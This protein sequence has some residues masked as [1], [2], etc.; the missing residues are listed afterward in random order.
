MK[1]TAECP[2]CCVIV[3]HDSD[4]EWVTCPECG[5]LIGVERPEAAGEKA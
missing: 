2:R 3:E 5:E 1:T 4:A